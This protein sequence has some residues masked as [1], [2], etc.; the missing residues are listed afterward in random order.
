MLFRDPRVALGKLGPD[1]IA[2]E[3]YNGQLV[4]PKAMDRYFALGGDQDGRISEVLGLESMKMLPGGSYTL[5]PEDV[6]IAADAQRDFAATLAKRKT[7]T[8]V[9]GRNAL[10]SA[11]SADKQMTADQSF[12]ARM[13]YDEKNLY[14]RYEVESSCELTNAASDP[15]TIFK[16]GNL[17]D[18]QLA[19]DATADPKR[20]APV[21]GDTRLLVTRKE[22]KVFAVVYRPVVKDF[23]GT[24]QVLSSPTGSESFDAI[25]VCDLISLNYQSK[26]SGFSAQINIPLSVLNW[27]PQPG[28]SV[29]MDVGY[30]FGNETGT[31]ATG[32][33]YWSNTGF[34][35]GVLNDIPNESRLDPSLWGS[36]EVE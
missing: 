3:N 2:S 31:R 21:T 18:I 16:G 10:D 23:K 28:S 29:R 7:I 6:K 4:K 19:A 12:K 27:R 32:R 14:V 36:V 26:T 20:K 24:K 17:L 15:Q 34:S 30:I 35:A 11:P 22:G 13:A 8:I 1:I 5:S 25:E 33:C 9:R